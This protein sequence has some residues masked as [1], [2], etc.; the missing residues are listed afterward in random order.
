ML[1]TTVVGSW[2]PEERFRSALALYFRGQMDGPESESLLKEVAAVAIAQQQACG[3]DE[4]TGGETSADSFILHFPRFLTGIE[5]TD[6]RDAWDGRGSYAVVGPLGARNGLGIAAAF[7]RERTIEPRLAKVTIPG[8]S[9]IT[10]ML[11]PREAVQ[12]AWPAVIDLIRAEIRQLILAGA[13]DVQL[14]VPQIAMGL[15]DGGWQT[16]AAVDVIAAIFAD[17]TMIRRSVHLCYGDFGARSWVANRALSPLIP[18][19]QAL[20]GTVDRVVLE[21]SLPE[22]WAERQ[23]LAETPA[24]LEIAAGIVDVKEPR[25]QTVAELSQLAEQLLTVVPAA[26]LL[27]CPSCGLGRR[28]VPL[29]IAKVTGMVAAA[30]SL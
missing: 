22:Q 16:A 21:L 29:A 10:T 11:E 23:L 25:V 17:F 26:R 27:L 24:R 14:D 28:T 3:L 30:K 8:P 5:P 20:G 2:P 19:I 13:T 9:E 7:R 1:R 4:Y 15:A 12:R 6:Q 18:T